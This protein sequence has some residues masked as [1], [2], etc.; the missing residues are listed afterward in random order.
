MY[1]SPNDGKKEGEGE[2]RKG[3]G[4]EEEEDILE[5]LILL[6]FHLEFS[7][8]NTSSSSKVYLSIVH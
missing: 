5:F 6:T 2:N 1:V 4:G 8:K 3:E 7:N